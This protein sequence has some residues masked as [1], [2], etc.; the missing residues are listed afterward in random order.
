MKTITVEKFVTAADQGNISVIQKYIQEGSDVNFVDNYGNIAILCA[1]MNGH[2][3][4]VRMLIDA[5]ADVD[6]QN[7]YVH[8]SR[9]S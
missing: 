8:C 1:A 9:W 2:K 6:S 3:E 5:G 7:I 4:I